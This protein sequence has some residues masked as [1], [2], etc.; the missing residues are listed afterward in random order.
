MR[1]ST[2][3][4]LQE[5][6]ET[7]R[8]T[9]SADNPRQTDAVL[10]T[11][12]DMSSPQ[13]YGAGV[14]RQPAESVLGALSN[15]QST[16]HQP[17]GTDPG[18]LGVIGTTRPTLSPLPTR[19]TFTNEQAGQGFESS[20]GYEMDKL[21]ST[22]YTPREVRETHQ[23]I[24]SAN[25]TCQTEVALTTSDMSSPQ[26]FEAGATRQPTLAPPLLPQTQT[27]ENDHRPGTQ[28]EKDLI[29]LDPELISSPWYAANA[30]GSGSPG[31]QS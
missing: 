17:I 13:A 28:K 7:R 26:R 1:V 8:V 23:I 5:V 16:T 24:L 3:Y 27:P 14:T 25:D 9:P 4:T 29:Q 2:S 10:L 6:R 19:S 11:T 30:L 21:G 22:S 12:A 31:T 20:E 18:N 15:G